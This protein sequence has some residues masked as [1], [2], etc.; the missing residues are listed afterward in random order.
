MLYLLMQHQ[1]L[2]FCHR[3]SLRLISRLSITKQEQDQLIDQNTDTAPVDS[4]QRD[5]NHIDINTRVN[6]RNGK[7][8]FLSPCATPSQIHQWVKECKI[9]HEDLIGIMSLASYWDVGVMLGNKINV[10]R[11]LPKRNLLN[12]IISPVGTVYPDTRQR[13]VLVNGLAEPMFQSL[14]YLFPL[15]QL[16]RKFY[17]KDIQ[18]FRLQVIIPQQ[19]MSKVVGKGGQNLDDIQKYAGVDSVSCQ[20][21]QEVV[22]GVEEEIVTVVGEEQDVLKAVIKILSLIYKDSY[23]IYQ[24]FQLRDPSKLGIE[25]WLRKVMI[26]EPR[27]QELIDHESVRYEYTT[28]L[29]LQE[30][31][32]LIGK[33]GRAI[34][35]TLA[36]AQGAKI[37]IVQ[38][39][40]GAELKIEG[41]YQQV[42]RA[43]GYQQVLLNRLQQSQVKHEQDIVE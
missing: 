18:K 15:M 27:L 17:L 26:K 40:E 9:G 35:Q 6:L 31:K 32:W 39:D 12:F 19:L 24:D 16:D 25:A 30:A 33:S 34:S 20:N 7:K 28:K 14:S 29:S 8:F 11:K 1:P 5:Q 13:I 2:K 23:K 43:L 42:Q 21:R 38:Q 37:K 3:Y 36:Y 4:S 22:P 41:K 10:V